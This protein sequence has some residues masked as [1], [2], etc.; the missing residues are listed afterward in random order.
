MTIEEIRAK[1]AEA[2]RAIPTS[3]E[4]GPSIGGYRAL[5][6]RSG[7]D[8][9]LEALADAIDGLATIVAGPR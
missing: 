1:I 2:R 6:E 5:R 3:T 8:L 9:A 7:R 4:Y